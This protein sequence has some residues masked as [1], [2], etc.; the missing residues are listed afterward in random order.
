MKEGTA[1]NLKR[2]ELYHEKAAVIHSFLLLNQLLSNMSFSRRFPA[3]LLVFLVLVLTIFAGCTREQAAEEP[4]DE[5]VWIAEGQ[6]LLLPFKQ[7]LMGALQ[8][9][10]QNGPESAI[11]ACR[12]EAPEIKAS[13]QLDWAAMGRTSHKL[14]NP[15]NAP[16]EWV[17]PLLDEY[18]S[19]PGRQGPKVVQLTDGRIGYVE[20]I[21]V[22]P[23]CL[24]CH[25]ASVAPGVESLLNTHYPEDDARGFEAGDFRGLFWVEFDGDAAEPTS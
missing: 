23:M 7:G 8:S 15:S 18:T 17:E 9:G 20:P 19:V 11:D 4:F 2:G 5:A 6:D 10:M 3:P 13:V 12:L 25:G 21:M 16:R 14:R 22:Q 1:S 24:T